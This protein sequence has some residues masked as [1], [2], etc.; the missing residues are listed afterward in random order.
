MKL[1]SKKEVKRMLGGSSTQWINKQVLDGKLI[2][3]YIANEPRFY[4]HQVEAFIQDNAQNYKD[5]LERGI[6]IRRGEVIA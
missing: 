2:A 5:I 3:I 1:L 4:A 6:K